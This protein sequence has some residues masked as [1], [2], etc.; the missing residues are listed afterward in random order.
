MVSWFGKFQLTTAN[1]FFG[2]LV[3][4]TELYVKP[5]FLSYLITVI[6]ISPLLSLPPSLPMYL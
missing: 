4:L 1:Y 2:I 5:L 3:F 6:V